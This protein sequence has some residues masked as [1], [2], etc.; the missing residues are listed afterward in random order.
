MGIVPL[1]IYLWCVVGIVISV[2]LPILTA[3]LPKPLGR[4]MPAGVIQEI[5]PY[6]VTGLFA[7]IA[8][9]V[10]IAIAGD[11]ALG[12]DSRTALVAGY[13][14]DSTLQKVRALY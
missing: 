3:L 1:G 9:V 7:A 11:A 6:V 8:A 10:V 4:T 13:T 12:W 2:V 5:R 14:W